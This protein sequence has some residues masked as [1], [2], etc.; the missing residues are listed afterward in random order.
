MR[1][2]AVWRLGICGAAGICAAY[3]V[4]GATLSFEQRHSVVDFLGL[5]GVSVGRIGGFR[6]QW[7]Q[8]RTLSLAHPRPHS[9]YH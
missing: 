9:H 8:V 2:S 4:L 5:R 6:S 7:G 1:R 3:V